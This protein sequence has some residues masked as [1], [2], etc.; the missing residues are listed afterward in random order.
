MKITRR[1]LED[2]LPI[3]MGDRRLR[4]RLTEGGLEVEAVQIL[5]A[6]FSGVRVARIRSVDDLPD[7]RLR[8]CQV[9]SA[10]QLAV[11]VSG[12][13]NLH[14]GQW[15]VWAPPGARLPGRDP[16]TDRHF[17]DVVSCGMLCSEQELGIGARA[18]R[19]LE[20]PDGC[21]TGLGLDQLLEWPDVLFEINVTPNRGDCLSALGLAREVS[22]LTGVAL[23]RSQPAGDFHLSPGRPVRIDAPEACSRFLGLEFELLDSGIETP[24]ALRV[25][26]GRLGIEPIHPV[27][28]VT[29]YVMLELGQPLHAYDGEAIGNGA[30]TVRWG[31]EGESLELLNERSVPLDHSYLVVASPENPLGLAGVM[32]GRS[33]AVQ[34]GSRRFFLESAH[35]RTSAVAGRARRLNCSSEAA[36][37]FE[38]GVDPHLTGI[39][40]ARA[41]ELL[42][43]IYGPAIRFESLSEAVGEILQPHCIPFQFSRVQKQLGC[44]LQRRTVRKYLEAIGCTVEPSGSGFRVGP[45]SFRGD[46]NGPEDLVEEVARLHGYQRLP[47]RPLSGPLHR[48]QPDPSGQRMEKWRDRL[49]ERGYH[50]TISLALVDPDWDQAFALPEADPVRL[51]NPLSQDQS[52]LRRSLWPC[53][54][55]NLAYNQAREQRRVRIFESGSVFREHGGRK[56]EQE[57]IAGL[58]NGSAAEVQWGIADREV[59]FFDVKSDLES[60]LVP[61]SGRLRF[62]PAEHPALD[63]AEGAVL[64]LDDR[65]IGFLGALHPK[66]QKRWELKGKTYLWSLI[67]IEL[68]TIFEVEYRSAPRFPSVRRDLAFVLPASVSLQD[69]RNALLGSGAPYLHE[70]RLFDVYTGASMPDGFR[71]LAFGLIFRDEHSTLTEKAIN[72]LCEKA[73][74]LIEGEF[75]GR[76]RR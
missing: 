17:G 26:L 76:L 63:P 2:W 46:L 55:R 27:V 66:L 20:L 4:D 38:R 56:S 22:A 68:G 53:L 45:P 64:V 51:L 16:L 48:L 71:S 6:P 47:V 19:I 1:W 29:Q 18:D 72:D 36:L 60:L 24:L 73:V 33:T 70:V 12:A 25:R 32:G 42:S 59:D 65:R 75:R 69:V 5:S 67:L 30:L 57:E 34:S 44:R 28:D 74:V 13:P 11:V 41:M 61:A 43:G 3:R 50:E 10:A 62:E 40:M 35:F 8:V 54:V 14:P 23:H 37:R 7:G 15:V 9:E 49:V 58:W 39:A 21:R 52:V 31:R